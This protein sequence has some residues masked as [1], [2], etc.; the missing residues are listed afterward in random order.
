MERTLVRTF[1]WILCNLP[2]KLPWELLYYIMCRASSLWR[3]TF[4]VPTFT[5]TFFLSTW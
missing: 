4:F 2:T 3:N 5:W 1:C